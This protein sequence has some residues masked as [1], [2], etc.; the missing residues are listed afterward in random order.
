MKFRYGWDT[1]KQEFNCNTSG[2]HLS[3]KEH[4]CIRMKTCLLSV[5]LLSF[6]ASCSMFAGAG[7]EKPVAKAYGKELYVS[8]ILEI[9]PSGITKDDSLQILKNYIE[10]WVRKQVILQR[11]EANLT[12]D[13]QNVD[14]LIDDYRTSLLIYKY[15]QKY[16]SQKLDTIISDDQIKSF[17]ES[18]K[19]NLVLMNSI[20]KALFVKISNSSPSLGK[21]KELYRSNKDEEIK[22]MDDL[23]IQG[24]ARYDYFNEQWVSFNYVLSEVPYQPDSQ[25][26]FLRKNQ[27]LEFRDSLFTYL[28]NIKDY[29]LK[30]ELAPLSYERDNIKS[31]IL[32]QRKQVLIKDLEIKMYNEA[33]NRGQFKVFVQ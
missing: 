31:V 21:V 20:V 19:D 6:F 32:N 14:Q 23:C 18:N 10:G 28:L 25:E 13:Q 16:L 29:K 8:Q 33:L 12:S 7:S 2:F 1:E 27:S 17:Y 15:E 30:G 11:A 26:E 22:A 4:N 3:L 24:A 5:F 9:F